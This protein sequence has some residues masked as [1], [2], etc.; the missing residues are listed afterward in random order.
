MNIRKVGDEVTVNISVKEIKAMYEMSEKLTNESDIEQLFRISVEVIQNIYELDKV[1][2]MLY[3]EDTESL[4][5]KNSVGINNSLIEKIVVNKEDKVA[6]HVFYKDKPVL[7]KN[8]NEDEKWRVWV[9]HMVGEKINPELKKRGI[10]L[11]RQ[12]EFLS[13]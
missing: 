4:K 13:A 9:E 10:G 11:D 1:S 6:G 12:R 8:M 5:I 3:D 2:I 7:I